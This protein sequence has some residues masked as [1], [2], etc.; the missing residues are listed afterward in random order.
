MSLADARK[1]VAAKSD[2]TIERETARKWADRAIA[3]F[4]NYRLGVR[5]KNGICWQARAEDYSHEALEHAALAR[6]RG[7]TLARIEKLIE[8]AQRNKKGRG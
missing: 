3:C 7:R 4:E 5:P 6:D 2:R 8:A 1:E